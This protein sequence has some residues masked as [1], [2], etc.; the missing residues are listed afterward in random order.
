[1]FLHACHGLASVARGNDSV[2]VMLQAQLHDL[3]QPCVAVD[4]QYLHGW[5]GLH[6]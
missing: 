4:K 5:P 1:M 6:R 2:A 3:D